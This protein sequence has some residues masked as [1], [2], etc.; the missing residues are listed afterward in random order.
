MTLFDK[1]TENEIDMIDRYRR[2]Y[3][4]NSYYADNSPDSVALALRE[5]DKSKEQMCQLLGGNLILRKEVL[6]TEPEDRLRSNLV[7]NVKI[8][9][10]VDDF[11][12]C[13]AHGGYAELIGHR[14]D[15]MNLVRYDD[16]ITNSFS[17][18]PFE[19]HLRGDKNPTKIQRGCKPVKAL[20]HFAE[21]Y[22]ISSYEDFRL[23][24][25]RIC[26][27]KKLKGTLC[28]SIHPL[29]FMT[30]SDNDSD[31][32]SCMSWREDGE[33]HLGTIEM[34][35]SPCVIMAYLESST[36]M[37]MG[38]GATWSNKKWRSLYVVDDRIITEIKGYPYQ[39]SDLSTAVLEWVRELARDN[40]G[41]TQFT[42]KVTRHRG[43]SAIDNDFELS[44]DFRTYYMYNDFG[45]KDY[46]LC[47]IGTDSDERIV[48]RYS[49]YPTC[50]WCGRRIPVD[51]D[52]PTDCLLGECCCS[53]VS[54]TYCSCC[55]ERIHGEVYWIGD[56]P[57]CYDCY[58]NET[59]ED[60][61]T[62]EQV[63]S[64]DLDRVYLVNGNANEM[65]E[66]L[67]NLTA[68]ENSQWFRDHSMPYI[69][70]INPSN[71]KRYYYSQTHRIERYDLS[72][73]DKRYYSNTY[74]VVFMDELTEDG[75][76]LFYNCGEIDTGSAPRWKYKSLD[77]WANDND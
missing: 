24:H 72:W 5:W 27:L 3:G 53:S 54:K 21:V 55:E 31:W 71:G 6:F 62:G 11:K 8:R 70:T 7:N 48:I 68:E 51:E 38:K 41:W 20:R 28:L 77:A 49:G 76:E 43:H 22:N 9:T 36:P 44:F 13:V 64:S 56:S 26:N 4:E 58:C 35:N 37:D 29:D 19:V 52:H 65:L 59:E 16:L 60:N 32:T 63:F 50:I 34:M 25:S 39:S 18:E 46:H 17:D 1:L 61:I 15:L 30:M 33:Y 74:N 23:E 10:F 40:L 66:E 67:G 69:Q 12:E 75:K 45:C 47:L 14:Y 42:G 57:L 73:W 2:D